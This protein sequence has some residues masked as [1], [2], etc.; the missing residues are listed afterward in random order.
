MIKINNNN[1]I[2]FIN[3]Y[4]AIIN[5]KLIF[6]CALQYDLNTRNVNLNI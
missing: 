4:C 1:N 6:N 2:N 3:F 5:I